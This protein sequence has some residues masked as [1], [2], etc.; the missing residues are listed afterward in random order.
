MEQTKAIQLTS[1]NIPAIPDAEALASV[2]LNKSIPH[3]KDLVEGKRIVWLKEQIMS[4]NMIRHQMVEGWQVEVDAKTLDEFIM[5]DHFAKDYTFSEIKDAF[6]RGLMGD[7]GD[8][9][10]LT[11]ESLYGFIRGYFMSEKKRKA[12][13]IVRKALSPDDSHKGEWYLE[14][15][16]AHAEEMAKRNKI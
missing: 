15:V 11:A 1:S 3:Y 13:E 9:Y 5:D 2:R 12:T 7:Y 8:Y 16:R 14:K 10:G 4:L 6:K